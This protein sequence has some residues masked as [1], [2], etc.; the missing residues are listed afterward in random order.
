MVSTF[1]P[2]SFVRAKVMVFVLPSRLW[3]ERPD[4]TTTPSFSVHQSI[5]WSSTFFTRTAIGDPGLSG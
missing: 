5:V 2:F 4:R 1:S 3:T